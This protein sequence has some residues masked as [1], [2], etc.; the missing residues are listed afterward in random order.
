MSRTKKTSLRKAFSFLSLNNSHKFVQANATDVFCLIVIISVATLFLFYQIPK[1]FGDDPITSGI[2]A[3]LINEAHTSNTP[4]SQLFENLVSSSDNRLIPAHVYE[5]FGFGL[6]LWHL[7]L[8]VTYLIFGVSVFDTLVLSSL[9]GLLT[10][11]LVYFLGKEMYGRMTG[12]LSAIL[13][14]GSLLF[15]FYVRS[16]SGFI[17]LVPLTVLSA[18]YFFYVAHERMSRRYLWISGTAI[19]LA[20]FNG[21]S[22]VFLLIPILLVSVIW[23][24]SF[25]SLT[26]KRTNSPAQAERPST[27]DYLL[28]LKKNLFRNLFGVKD[29][30]LTVV[31]VLGTFLLLAVGFDIY[32]GQTPLATALLIY[33]NRVQQQSLLALPSSFDLGVVLTS[34]IK[35]FFGDMFI[36]INPFDTLAGAHTQHYLPDAPYIFPF[37]SIFLFAG[38]ALSIKRRTVADKTCLI[39]WSIPLFTFTILSGFAGRAVIVMAPIIYVIAAK[40]MVDFSQ[41]FKGSLSF[42]RISKKWPHVRKWIG[43]LAICFGVVLTSYTSYQDVFQIYYGQQNGRIPRYYGMSG[44]YGYIMDHSKPETSEIVLGDPILLPYDAFVFYTKGQ[45][46][47]LYWQES[48]GPQSDKLIRNV[49]ALDEWERNILRSKSDIF[50]VFGLGGRY[51]EMPGWSLYEGKDQVVSYH[52]APSII[53]PDSSDGGAWFRE[54]HPALQPVQTVYFNSG[55]PAFAIYQVNKTTPRNNLFSLAMGSNKVHSF[56]QSEIELLTIRGPAKNVTIST[57]NNRFNLPMNV[58][59]SQTYSI[60]WDQNSEIVFEP[61]IQSENYVQDIFEQK[62][63]HFNNSQ[64]AAWIELDEDSGYVVYKIESPFGKIRSVTLQTN[65]RLFNDQEQKNGISFLYSVDNTRYIPIYE[66][67]SNG[68]GQ[69][70]SYINPYSF[71]SSTPTPFQT[72]QS[73][74]V[75]ERQTYNEIYPDSSVVYL[76]FLL[77]G[78]KGAVQL[79]SPAGLHRMFFIAQ[80][81]TSSAPRL[82]LKQGL[83]TVELHMDT[84]SGKV[85]LAASES[86]YRPEILEAGNLRLRS[87]LSL[88]INITNPRTNNT[89][90]GFDGSDD[91]VEAPDHTG[92]GGRTALSIEV[93]FRAERTANDVI[94]RKESVYWSYI[95][96]GPL[97]DGRYTFTIYTALYNASTGVVAST[98]GWFLRQWYHLVVTYD[99]L[100]TK[101]YRDG[102]EIYSRTTVTGALNNN[103]VP[104]LLGRALDGSQPFQGQIK[105]V[106][107]YDRVLNATEV[108]DLSSDKGLVVYFNTTSWDANAGTWHDLSGHG[109]DGTIHGAT[110]QEGLLPEASLLTYSPNVALEQG[111][112]QAN[113]RLKV[114]DNSLDAPVAKVDVIAGGRVLGEFTLKGT[115]FLGSNAY[116]LFTLNFTTD[117]KENLTFRVQPPGATAL[118]ADYI[119]VAP[120]PLVDRFNHKNSFASTGITVVDELAH[121][122]KAR[123]AAM[124][125]EGLL[126]YSPNVTLRE[127]VYQANFRL[128][129]AD[130]SLDIPVAKID[131]VAGDKVIG[132]FTLNG[133]DFLRSNTYQ[134]FT[135]NFTTDG[136]ENLTFRVHYLGATAL[137]ADYIS[138][139]EFVR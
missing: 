18:V 82:D 98:S 17:A 111:T 26:R 13:L 116:Q 57:D 70:S 5:S 91:Y 73:A 55:A 47:V 9:I 139:Y 28:T 126:V 31:I 6:P 96:P 85:S 122:G 66:T 110:A 35:K 67:K 15:I 42:R 75:F 104:I 133:T 76:K 84:D 34:N 60:T 52:G 8:S 11:V 61:L 23:K 53:Q 71:Y 51:T 138:I 117:G 101:I 59:P 24:I 14:S 16:G 135:F 44:V 40:A 115:D 2:V 37:V 25:R 7:I 93:W 136:K 80:F 22:P 130:N 46:P 119:Y 125:Q 19:G 69:W 86:V 124:R 56:T 83:N 30:L 131:V 79:W 89:W 63:I 134:V 129:V 58:L 12:F 33:T 87:A 107:L 29:Y 105:E 45:Y 100:T 3:K 72:N 54:L 108:Q 123:Y 77:T 27:K 112:Y 97:L 88:R 92:L 32:T 137:W 48:I 38:L 10:I 102:I 128:K 113:F 41:L 39:W 50:Y 103:T 99:G 74:G 68:N 94:Y 64:G 106:R 21:Y 36:A 43:V 65:L 132:G 118:W 78:Q 109:N 114:A 121:D 81:D 20:F 1:D 120:F 127:G 49:S 62:N 90:I 4:T 95:S